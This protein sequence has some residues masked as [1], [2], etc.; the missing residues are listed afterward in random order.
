M[1]KP[2][3]KE[4]LTPIEL[5][6]LLRTTRATIYEYIKAG[7]L[8]GIKIGRHRLF[9]REEVTA[10][11]GEDPFSRIPPEI[12]PSPEL[13]QARE[14]LKRADTMRRQRV[15]REVVDIARQ[16]Q[17]V[18]IKAGDIRELAYAQFVEG[19][20]LLNSGEF[21]KAAKVLHVAL[22]KAQDVEDRILVGMI[23]ATL[24]MVEELRG[25]SAQAINNFHEAIRIFQE[26]GPKFRLA[27]VLQNLGV[28]YNYQKRPLEALH[29]LNRA[30]AAARSIKM[31]LSFEPRVLIALSRT[32]FIIGNF[33]QSFFYASKAWRLSL[34]RNDPGSIVI[35]TTRMGHALREN[36]D[37]SGARE[38]FLLSY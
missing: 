21:N 8:K 29:Y 5:A 15:G 3:R 30:V 6:E 26:T 25:N 37:L 17:K 27:S 16:V 35:A 33:T 1:A 23:N 24:G 18:F 19:G 10:F 31:H 4:Y 38:F 7:K 2:D 36:G 9:S 22:N 32:H 11:L 13:E 34:K 28:L 14:E 12:T 20:G